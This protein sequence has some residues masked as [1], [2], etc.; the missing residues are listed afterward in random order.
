MV[1][2]VV[3]DGGPGRTELAIEQVGGLDLARATLHV[4]PGLGRLR[5]GRRL[6][7]ARRFFLRS[8]VGRLILPEGAGE[9]LFPGFGQVDPLP[10][11][12]AVADLLAL[13]ALE[14]EGLAPG[15]AAVALSGPRL[16]PELQGTAQRLCPLVR[17]LAIDVPGEGAAFAAWLHRR[18]GL[19]VRPPEGAAAT[20]AFG[21]G[22]GRWGRALEL[23]PEG[24]GLA[25]LAVT[26]P[27]LALPAGCEGQLLAALW[28]QGRLERGKLRVERAA[29]ADPS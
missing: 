22:G 12:R 19:P 21:P 13:G 26:A 29:G 15:R 4:P 9:A 25:G 23:Y 8:G 2:R 6:R 11:Y 1:G 20:V 27:E 17:G 14:A 18:Y 3:W 28:E 24:A 5:L 16:S 10:F 7:A